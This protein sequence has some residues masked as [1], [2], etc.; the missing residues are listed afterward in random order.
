HYPSPSFLTMVAHPANF[1]F[2]E[3]Y[4]DQDVHYYKAHTVGT[5]PFKL[6][7]YV[8]GSH[9]EL[10]RNPEYWKKGLPYM[11]GIKYFIIKDTSARAMAIRSGRADVEFRGFPPTEA[12]AIQKQLGDRVVVAY[13]KAIINWGVA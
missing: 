11:D 4:L 7:N 10:E 1:I 3:K 9:I 8:R 2:A 5:G 12:E 6:K 13:P